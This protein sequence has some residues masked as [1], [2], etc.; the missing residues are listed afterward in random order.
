MSAAINRARET[1]GDFLAA[2]KSPKP[3][4]N[5]FLVK[6]PFEDGQMVEHMWVSDLEIK[7]PTLSGILNNYPKDIRNYS[8]GQP[9]VIDASRI[10]DWMYVQDGRLVG[11]YTLRV[12][13]KSYSPEQLRELEESQGYKIE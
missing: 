3:N 13:Y 5:G 6:F 2:L 12:M 4:Q 1:R 8:Y 7:G 10:S 9:V 11:G